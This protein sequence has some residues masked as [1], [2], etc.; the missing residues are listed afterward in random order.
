V[1]SCFIGNRG[2]EVGIE[3]KPGFESRLEPAYRWFCGNWF[4]PKELE[5]W[6]LRDLQVSSRN[7][8]ASGSLVQPS[9]LLCTIFVA[10]E[11]GRGRFMGSGKTLRIGPGNP[12]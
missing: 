11:S 2:R 8:D 9:R 4:V 7:D 6:R 3:E 1:C 12:R 10:L 5:L